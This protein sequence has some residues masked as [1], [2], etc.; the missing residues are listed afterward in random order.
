MD[1]YEMIVRRMG[2]LSANGD[3]IIFPLDLRGFFGG[4]VDGLRS[5]RRGI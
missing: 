3:E 5:V 4:S 1:G 2:K